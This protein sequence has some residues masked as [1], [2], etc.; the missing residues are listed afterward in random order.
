MKVGKQT[1]CCKSDFRKSQVSGSWP[2]AAAAL[3]F[4]QRTVSALK[5][6]QGAGGI[7]TDTFKN[8]SCVKLIKT[9]AGLPVFFVVARREAR[10]V[11]TPSRAAFL[12]QNRFGS[13]PPLMFCRIPSTVPFYWAAPPFRSVPTP[14]LCLSQPA[15]VYLTKIPCSR[16]TPLDMASCVAPGVCT[17]ALIVGI[18]SGRL[19]SDAN[20][21]STRC[22]Y[23]RRSRLSDS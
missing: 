3:E 10:L 6:V 19:L 8:L 13:R 14:K 12:F 22:L 20:A 15:L 9:A 1:P 11:M 18:P 5:R 23:I 7:A 16:I 17:I 21:C 2:G 4:G